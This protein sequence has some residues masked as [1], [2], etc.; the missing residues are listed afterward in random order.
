MALTLLIAALAANHRQDPQAALQTYQLPIGLSVALPAKPE[1]VK[2]E[3][4]DNR[5]AFL[6]Y[7]DDAVYFVSDS[8]VDKEEQAALA[9]DE[10]IAAYICAALSNDSNKHLMK[11]S[12]ALLDGWPGVEFT[13]EDKAL[14][15]AVCSRCFEMDGHLVEF[16]A[17]YAAGG[18]PPAGLPSFLSS[19]HQSKP[20]YGPVTSVS[21]GHTQLEPDGASFRLDF[22]GEVHDKPVQLGKGDTQ[23]LLHCFQFARDLRTFDFTYLELP[24]GAD[25]SMPADGPEQLR[26]DTL[27]AILEYFKA[28]RDSSTIEQRDGNDWLTA[29]FNL[30][31]IGYGLADI[32]YLKGRVYALVAIGPECWSDSAEFKQF[33]D[34]FEI[35]NSTN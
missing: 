2:P 1:L 30:K 10:Q 12:D 6:S 22:P 18:E 35:K 7:G 19:I 5:K 21:F 3:K 27:D 16:G 14:G 24:D 34:S 11:Y 20:K 31:G 32:L 17:I 9:P 23:A 25:Q 26:N 29:H 13:I 33:F 8:P 28:T 15:E 4:G